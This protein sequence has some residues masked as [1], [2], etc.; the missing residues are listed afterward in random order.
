[1]LSGAETGGWIGQGNRCLSVPE[2][3]RAQWP[4]LPHNPYRKDGRA[5]LSE[6]RQV[7]SAQ[8]APET[9]QRVFTLGIAD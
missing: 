3:A 9:P 6:G 1:M 7:V 8:V 5:E 2:D 4:V